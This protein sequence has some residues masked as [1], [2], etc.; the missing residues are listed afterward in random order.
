MDRLRQSAD[1]DREFEKLAVE[2]GQRLRADAPIW[3]P[4]ATA[5]TAATSGDLTTT[6]M[7]KTDSTTTPTM[8]MT[9]NES[10]SA[11]KRELAPD[12]Q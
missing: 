1:L 5:A 12:C 3:R 7:T 11:L 10:W 8:T 6:T 9:S 2:R 4:V